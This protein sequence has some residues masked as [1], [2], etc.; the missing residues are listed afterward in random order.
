MIGLMTAGDGRG[1][2]KRA[3]RGRGGG[4]D[5]HGDGGRRASHSEQGPTFPAPIFL[6]RRSCLGTFG[7]VRC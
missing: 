3:T 1:Q 5:R 6:D 4:R 7:S 2:L